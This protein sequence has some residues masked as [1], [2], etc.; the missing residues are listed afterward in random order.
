MSVTQVNSMPGPPISG[1]TAIGCPSRGTTT[2]KG[3][4]GLSQ[5]CELKP[6]K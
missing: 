1:M 3:R 2:K 4:V 6:E 5:N